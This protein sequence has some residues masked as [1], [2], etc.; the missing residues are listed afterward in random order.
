MTANDN[1]APQEK[2]P[3]PN[4][5]RQ[6]LLPET[7]FFVLAAIV[8][9][10]VAA[11]ADA[12][13]PVQDRAQPKKTVSLEMVAEPPDSTDIVV[14][15]PPGTRQ[16]PEGDMVVLQARRKGVPDCP[17]VWSGDVT[18]GPSFAMP[19][20]M[21]NTKRVAAEFGD[22]CA[23]SGG[24]DVFAAPDTGALHTFL[25][26]GS[27]YGWFSA[28]RSKQDVGAGIT[29]M[30]SGEYP[31]A[32]VFM[33]P[34][35]NFEH[36]M[37]GCTADAWRAQNTPRTDPMEVRL[38]SSACVEI[39]WPA[40]TSKW[41]L[42]CV[43]R[44]AFS[45][46]NAI[47][48]EFE[49]TPRANEAPLGYLVF[50]W[51][52][53]INTAR[54]RTISFPAVRDGVEGWME[55]GGGESNGGA[56]A[57]VGQTGLK[58][59]KDAAVLNLRTEEEL[60]FS[61]PVY[62]GLVDGDQNWQTMDDTMAVIMMFDNPENTRFAVWNWGD[63]PHSSAWDW[64]Y[65]VRS[66]EVGRTYHHRAR[67]VYKRFQGRD[68]VIAEYRS[69]NRSILPVENAGVAP[70]RPFPA[71]WS[72]GDDGYNPVVAA[73]KAVQSAP[74]LALAAYRRL[75]GSP[76]Y[77]MMAANQID[78]LYDVA[79][80]LA[81]LAAEWE[82]VAAQDSH[83][84]LA[85]NRLGRVRLR[86][87][88]LG[89]AAEA[90]QRG[91]DRDANDRECRL[92]MGTVEVLQNNLE[93]GLALLDGVV[94][95]DADYVQRAGTVCAD[96]AKAR[97]ATGDLPGALTLLRKARSL[98]PEDLRYNEAL[99]GALEAAGDDD[100]ALVEYRG[101][102][103]QAPESPES[104]HSSDRM[105]AIY[106]RRND[107]GAR[108]AE[109]KSLAQAH[110]DA[111]TQQLHL[112][113]ALEDSGNSSGAEAAYR[114]AVRLR[115]DWQ[116]SKL[117]LGKIIAAKGNVEE[118]LR[119][120]N[121]AVDAMPDLA[122]AA[123]EACGRAA[124]TR[125]VAGDLPGA[126]TL[127]RRARNLLPSDLGYRVALGETLEAAE[128]DAEALSEYRAV[129]L[130]V[131][132]SPHSSD[133]MDAIYQRRNDPGARVAEW[134]SLAQAHPDAATPQ[135]HLGMA[136][137]DS[138]DDAG[139]EAAYREAMRLRPERPEPKVRLGVIIAAKGK[140]EEGLRL[141]DEAVAAM[142]DLAGPAAAG[143]DRAAKVRGSSGDTAGALT[144]LRR[145]RSLSPTDL[146]YCVA[147][148]E[149]LE[150]AGDDDGALGEY[151]AVLDEVPESPH[152][153][154]R[155]DAVYQRRKDI[156]GLVAEWRHMVEIHPDAAWPRLHLGLAL[157]AN[158]DLGG[159]ET[160]YCGALS[161]NAA[162]DTDS[163]LFHRIKNK[164]CGA[165]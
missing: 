79:G 142:P 98:S 154:E 56:V 126:L 90:F 148:G 3:A 145:A 84:A 59:E 8:V 108:V 161:R 132:E 143:C 70:L 55:F 75:L 106:Q 99:G 140:T 147:V 87:G 17:P 25:G 14:C 115:P 163:T 137:E 129:V 18:G 155:I 35:L 85:W 141:L 134:K 42:D 133:R 27:L 100:G 117:S 46:Q 64:Q 67:M 103:M 51:A 139:A 105:D 5:T 72:P 1:L 165:P 146:R 34:N 94:R 65:V 28:N 96:A 33:R 76:F 39:R 107:P 164:E 89:K 62:Y 151:R 41:K 48:M 69:W 57:G 150:A 22:G 21:D 24:Q 109:W 19:V 158:G 149:A 4:R 95:E 138:G 110:P 160:A 124:K 16:I 91:L 7:V 11:H 122:G 152:C 123:A 54:A 44:Y 40:Q 121:E 136:L 88:E 6:R 80:N 83:D 36:I 58:W 52:S 92:G 73:N 63:D 130:G 9:S 47:D 111:A 131:P 23:S 49:V 26:S 157:E 12:P 104:P 45:G 128:N 127:L 156:S 125:V 135:L 43:M 74:A 81:G 77:Q 97:V 53:Y 15:P 144:L 82:S 37:N 159:A 118:G 78:A 38:L 86:T 13:P 10:A 32:P 102:V 50:M 116:N 120:V 153:S 71:Y 93:A 60:R 112:G 101:V 29:H 2:P 20:L 31:Y 119:L 113:M 162:V 66:P 30:V 61:E 114:E 68:D